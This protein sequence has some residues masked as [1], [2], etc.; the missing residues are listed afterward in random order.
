VTAGGGERAGRLS[1]A[2]LLAEADRLIA[3]LH[4]GEGGP[5]EASRPGVVGIGW[6]TVDL[7]RAASE[8]AGGLGLPRG[9][10]FQ[11]A[12]AEPFLGAFTRRVRVG[13][14]PWIV[15]LEP[16]TEGR[17]AA[18]LVRHDEGVAAVYVRASALEPGSAQ[19]AVL[20]PMGLQRPLAGDRWGPWLVAV[21]QGGG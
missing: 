2:G 15:L 18:F 6:A 20:G 8:L 21:E 11:T 5:A 4:G 19:A 9:G 3:E 14:G 10:A 17:L 16:S 1:L 7:D 13:S 12:A